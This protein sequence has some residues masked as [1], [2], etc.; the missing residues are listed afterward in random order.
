MKKTSTSRSAFFNVRVLIGLSILLAGVSLALLGLGGFSANAASSAQTKQKQKTAT[1]SI[2]LSLLPPGFDCSTIHEKG[3]DKQD[4]MRAG[5]IMIACGLAEGGSDPD[6]GASDTDAVSRLI[7]SLLP[8]PLFIGGSDVDVVLPDGAYPKVTQSESMSWGGPNNTWVVNYNDSRTS[9]VCY[10]GLSYSTDNGATWHAGQPLCTGHGTN[11]GDPIVVYNARL[12]KWFAGDLAGGCGGQGI[13]LWTST[14]GITW[15]TDACAASGSSLDRPS[16]WVDNSPGSPF[17]G[18]MYISFNNFNIG[19]GALYIFYSD[20]GTIWNQV[21][22]NPGFIRNIQ[23]T[24]DVQGSGRVYVAAMN[25]GSGGLTTRQNVMYRSTDGGV[26]WTSTNA[27]PSFQAPGRASC[28]QQTYF[29]CM[30]NNGITIWRHMG[31]GQ[32]A[33]SG[34][35]VSLTYAACGNPAGG[36]CSGQ[37]DHGNVYYIRSTDGGANWSVPL[38]LNTDAGTAMQ[39]QPSLAATQTGTLFAGWYDGREASGG[40]DLNCVAGSSTPCYR[41]W[42]RISFDN[43]ATWQADDMVG[44][45]LSGLPT[46]PDSAVRAEYEGDYDYS[47][48]NG[49]TAM[50]GWTDG[51][52]TIGGN[53]QQDVFVNL[54]QGPSPTASP[55]PTASAT[56]SPT[57][58]STPTPTP[59][60]GQYVVTQ[61][62]GTIVPGTTDIGNHTDD[63]VTTVALPFPF[64]LYDQSFTSINLSANGNAQFTTTDIEWNS[65]C[66]PWFSHSYTILPYWDDL[67]LINPGFGIFTSISGT[68]PNRIFNIEWRAQYFTGSGSAN[69]ELRLYEGQSRFDI[70][71]GTITGSNLAATA[72]VQ[73]DDTSFTSISAMALAAQPRVRKATRYCHVE[74]RRL[75][76]QPPSLLRQHLQSRVRR[77]HLHVRQRQQRQRPYRPVRRQYHHRLLHQLRL[78]YL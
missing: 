42:G 5:M 64:T 48:A 22:L 16:M 9:S 18:R 14:N 39:W 53:A 63:T 38:K 40:A 35:V 7:K 61:I 67:W 46:Q 27:G 68:A 50:G 49:V 37:T 19:G 54:V 41:R 21:P 8:E 47:S 59:C 28:T 51:R 10:A 77:L 13:G 74:H 36:A 78:W 4:N 2:D 76:Q 44:R 20:D 34:N 6:E 23:V 1:R 52:N 56:A 33:A 25:E 24:G 32:P 70:I 71:Y 30:F 26:S 73:K 69:F 58:T 60:V 55:T 12:G 15:T 65:I 75:R 45:A 11:F 43:G 29:A 31:W 62:A 17:Y 66:L 3:I 72:G 57:P